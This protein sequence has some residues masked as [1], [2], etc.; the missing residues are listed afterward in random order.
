MIQ[1]GDCAFVA[2]EIACIQVNGN[3]IE[4]WLRN[5]EDSWETEME[6]EEQARA[7]AAATVKVLLTL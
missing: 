2:S 3:V 4:T 5:T 7:V 1:I 6:T